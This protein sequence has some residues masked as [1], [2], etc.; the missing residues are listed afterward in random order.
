MLAVG[1]GS[2]VQ[3]F[4]AATSTLLFT[5][6]GLR[7]AS[8]VEFLAFSPDGKQI[9]ALDRAHNGTVHLWR[10]ADGERRHELPAQ[11]TALALAPDGKTIVTCGTDGTALVW[12]L[13]SGVTAPTSRPLQH[14][15]D[16]EIEA[17]W[18]AL[19]LGQ[20]TEPR[21]EERFGPI[22]SLAE[23]GDHTVELFSARLLDP[24]LAQTDN[25][26]VERLIAPLADADAH[27]RVQAAER[28][29]AAGVWPAMNTTDV[30]KEPATPATVQILRQV[31]GDLYRARRDERVYYVLRQIGTLRARWLLHRIADGLPDDDANRYRK[32]MAAETAVALDQ[33]RFRNPELEEKPDIP[34]N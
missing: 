2:W 4:D 10:L 23:G 19:A 13:A 22:E 1:R 18:A 9:A 32:R 14:F 33:A 28:L 15:T 30:S 17:R 3:V 25:D 24:L 7:F 5:L 27:V 31:L 21:V 29:Q 26:E 20:S 11:A 12:D 8:T 34:R 6:R 16:R